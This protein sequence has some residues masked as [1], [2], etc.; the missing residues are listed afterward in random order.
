LQKKVYQYTPSPE[1]E[2]YIISLRSISG[3]YGLSL[4]EKFREFHMKIT[5]GLGTFEQYNWMG[6]GNAASAD[7]GTGEP[8]APN[9]SPTSGTAN[10][11]IGSIF[12]SLSKL[13]LERFAAGVITDICLKSPEATENHLIDILNTFIHS[14]GGMMTFAIGDKDTYQQIYEEVK[15]AYNTMSPEETR[16]ILK[17]HAHVNVRI[18]GWQ[19]PFITLPLSHM[20][21]YIQRP[22]GYPNNK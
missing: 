12:A 8:L 1:N 15:S 2:A 22:A 19:T 14:K 7:R 9:F 4:E 5:A 21:N 13:E 6:M 17:K 10:D 11:D 3:Y 16:E 20:E 18:G